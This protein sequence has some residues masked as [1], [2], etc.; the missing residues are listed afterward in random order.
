MGSYSVL[1][2]ADVNSVRKLYVS[3]KLTLCKSSAHWVVRPE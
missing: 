2:S 1:K 3:G